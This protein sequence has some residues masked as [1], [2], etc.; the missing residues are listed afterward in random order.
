M[1]LENDELRYLLDIANDMRAAKGDK[2]LED[3]PKSVPSDGA[4][5]LVA[6]AFNYDCTVDPETRE[7]VFTTQKDRDTYLSIMDIS[8]AQGIDNYDDWEDEEG[9]YYSSVSA[10][11]T[12]ELIDIAEGFDAHLYEEYE[13]PTTETG[14]PIYTGKD[15]QVE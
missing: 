11:L 5:C 2:K 10:P 13:V 6:N 14:A 8:L 12:H 3:L 9:N 4:N 1:K 7:I 15:G